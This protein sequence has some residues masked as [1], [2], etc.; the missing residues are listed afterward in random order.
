MK[1]RL[2]QNDRVLI[3]LRSRGELTT[4]QAVM[5]LDIMCLPKRISELREQGHVIDMTYR[6]SLNGA[7]FGV[8]TLIKD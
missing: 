3:W 7:R 8:Y 5:E 1:N 4:R 6:T 2:S